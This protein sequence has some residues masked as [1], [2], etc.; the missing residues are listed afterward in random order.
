[1]LCGDM[2]SR[3]HDQKPREREKKRSP[4]RP[5]Q[6]TNPHKKETEKK[7]GK[8]KMEKNPSNTSDHTD[9]PVLGEARQSVLGR[10]GVDG[11]DGAP[12]TA[13]RVGVGVVGSFTDSG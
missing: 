11:R 8:R 13:M 10:A 5:D 7:R 6:T 3:T 2:V 4:P 1:M 9:N 12:A